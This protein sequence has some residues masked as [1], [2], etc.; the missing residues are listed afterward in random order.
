MAITN[1]E[2]KQQTDRLAKIYIRYTV[3]TTIGVVLC[4][5]SCLGLTFTQDLGWIGLFIPAALYSCVVTWFMFKARKVFYSHVQLIPVHDP[6]NDSE[7]K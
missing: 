5:V 2:I 3:L 4:I 1:Q 6:N 7:N